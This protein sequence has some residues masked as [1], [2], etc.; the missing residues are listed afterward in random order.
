MAGVWRWASELI[1]GDHAA[2]G[3]LRALVV[4]GSKSLNQYF[5]W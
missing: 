1:L 4:T 3:K 2:G 5:S